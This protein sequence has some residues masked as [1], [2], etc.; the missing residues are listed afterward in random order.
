MTDRH[1][2]RQIDWQTYREIARE[3]DRKSPK[4]IRFVIF[5]D[6]NTLLK[7]NPHHKREKKSALAATN[8]T[9]NIYICFSRKR[10][11]NPLPRNSR[12]EEGERRRPSRFQEK[13]CDQKSGRNEY[14]TKNLLPLSGTEINYKRIKRTNHY[15]GNFHLLKVISERIFYFRKYIFLYIFMLEME[16]F[17]SLF[18]IFFIVD[19]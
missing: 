3:V 11:T 10:E 12:R 4:Y 2:D 14:E 7:A 15:Q 1:I 16:L 9:Q 18:Y 17:I 5:L 8:I 6:L 19:P 13:V